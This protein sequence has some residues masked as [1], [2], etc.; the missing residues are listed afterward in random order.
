MK[1]KKPLVSV[2][3]PTYNVEEYI[4]EAIYS[5]MNQDYTN[6][7]LI[8]VNDG[9]TDYTVQKINK[10]KDRRIKLIDNSDQQNNYIRRNQGCR[11]AKGKYICVMDGDDIALPHRISKQIEILE[12]NQHILALGS[13]FISRGKI[14]KKP[15]E[16][17]NIKVWLL[18]NNTF[19]HPSLMIRKPVMKQINFYNEKYNYSSDYD[20]VCRIALSGTIINIPDI[21]MEYRFHNNQISIMH[22]QM[23]IEYADNIRLEYLNQCGFKLARFEMI[24]FTKMMNVHKIN[25]REI[26]DIEVLVKK[27]IYQ[28]TKLKFFDHFYLRYF[29]AE[30]LSQCYL[31]VKS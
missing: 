6:W 26:E 10:I 2:V 25:N 11:L 5:I 9:S 19:L 21:L 28:N 31:R 15:K 16:Y 27:I 29:L 13:D 7:E 8:I 14:I 23:Q 20:L 17:N 30:M 1:S 3:M 18:K 4:E 22:R 24:N 12:E